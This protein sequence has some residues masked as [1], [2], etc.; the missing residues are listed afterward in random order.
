MEELQRPSDLN[1]LA[2]AIVDQAV[3]SVPPALPLKQEKNPAA[4]AS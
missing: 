4:M 2:K 3:G 1:Q